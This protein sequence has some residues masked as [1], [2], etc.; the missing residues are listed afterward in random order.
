MLLSL[1]PTHMKTGHQRQ[2]YSPSMA[3]QRRHARGSALVG[4]VVAIL[5]F[6]VLA[7][8]IVPMVGSSGQQAVMAE[9]ATKAYLM[10]ES[11]FRYAASTFIKAG[12]RDSQRNDA[13]ENLDGNYTLDNNEGRFQLKVYSFFYEI[14]SITDQ[15]GGQT[16][17]TAH[18]PGTFPAGELT[19]GANL[20][21]RAEDQTYPLA[22]IS[23]VAGQDDNVTMII[24][25]S[26]ADFEVGNMIYPVA[27][28]SASQPPAGSIGGDTTWDISCND[29]TAGMFPERNGRIDLNGTYYTYRVRSGNLLQDIRDPESPNI[30]LASRPALPASNEIVLAPH[31]RLEST[32]IYGSGSTAVSRTVNYHTPLSLSDTTREA[33]FTD[34]FQNATD[35]QDVG[36]NL[37]TINSVDGDNALRVTGTSVEGDD[38]GS[39]TAF[40]PTTP[41]AQTIDFNASRSGSQEFL[42]YETQLKV[43]YAATINPPSQGYFPASP[44][45]TYVAA[46]LAIRLGGL[47][48]SNADI[49]N[50][51]T[52]GIS[53]LRGN[54]LLLLDGIPNELVPVGD[55]RLLVLWQQTGNGSSRQWLAYKE[56]ADAFFDEDFEDHP[57]SNL[58]FQELGTRWD[59]EVGG[60]QRTGSTVNWYYGNEMAGHNYD[61]DDA[62]PGIIQSESIT[63]PNNIDATLTFWSWHETE[64]GR[65]D[66]HD[67]KQVFIRE[68]LGGGS[69]GSEQLIRT[70]D[71]RGG[72]PGD[73]YLENLDLSSFAG[74]TIRIEFKF[75]PVDEEQNEFEGWYIDDV[76]VFYRWPAQEATIAV[77]LQ[78]ALVLPFT[79]GTSRIVQ[80]DRIFGNT[81]GT[82]G[83][84]IAPPMLTGGNWTAGAPAQGTMLLNRV[85]AVAPGPAFDGSSNEELLVIGGTGRARVAG[86][87]NESNDRR[88][89]VIR[90]YYAAANG[91]GSGSGNADPLDRNTEPYGRLG[92]DPQ[93]NDLQWPPDLD[94]DGN[95]TDDD[96][97]FTAAEDYFRL[98]E[99]D[100]VNASI[101]D[102][103]STIAF[104]SNDQG[105]IANAVIQNNHVDLESP[106]IIGPGDPEIG[107]HS[108]GD[109]ALNVFFD[110]FGIRLE[111]IE[112]DTVPIPVQQ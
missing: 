69:L 100:A 43:G 108:F 56:M 5:V 49:F 70:I 25:G 97:N 84:V 17:V 111:I 68:D 88:A 79:N 62:D 104:T 57:F 98:I 20:R 12:S 30:P 74:Q 38:R 72:A 53:F 50:V 59:P 26:S 6:S 16:Q 92:I 21:I 81:F 10:A 83:T 54:D 82:F 48:Q 27:V 22:S 95:W 19:L 11:G 13:L 41:E 31:V 61:Y 103:L 94:D 51:N 47:P 102:A 66:T 1:H 93:L 34:T 101:G 28:A 29:G 45:P 24:N 75:D 44:I 3:F 76:R 42:S 15:G 86:T 99:W 2:A 18:C 64:P 90:A 110:D 60:R 107:L 63:L 77:R 109:G 7:A 73:W 91:S 37:T 96:G 32:G 55:R 4:L 87:Y 112:E 36:G 8:A 33:D 67:L 65:L 14:L 58:F 52:Y 80:G 40:N 9:M 85:A 35:W 89:N 71:D 46:G 78:E 23:P 106:L 105:L 39:L